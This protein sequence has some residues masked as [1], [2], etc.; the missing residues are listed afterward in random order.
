M[1][2]QNYAGGIVFYKNKVLIVQNEKREWTLPKAVRREDIGGEAVAAQC[3]F[4]DTGIEA[5]VLSFVGT[6]SYEFYSLSR[7]CP[8]RNH[9]YWYAM[10]S[11]SLDAARRSAGYRST[12]FLPI[13]QAY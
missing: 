3:V 6:T 11:K 1:L 9:I 5:K 2:Q 7:N 12:I 10:I 8:V 13:E 4:E